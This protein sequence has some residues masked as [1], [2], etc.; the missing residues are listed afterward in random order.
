MSE[1]S[2]VVSDLTASEIKL[3]IERYEFQVRDAIRRMR[4]APT[5]V[6]ARIA[7]RSGNYARKQLAFLQEHAA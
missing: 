1:P 5:A 2:M 4:H 3:L 7:M 6:E